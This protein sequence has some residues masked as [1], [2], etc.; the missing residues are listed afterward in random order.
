MEPDFLAQKSMLEEHCEKRGYEVIFF[1]KYH[2]ELN[3]IEQC[4][5]YAKRIYRMFPASSKEEDLEK[6]LLAALGSVPLASMRRFSVRSSR[7][8]DAYFHGLDGA[9]PLLSLTHHCK[10]I[11][12]CKKNQSVGL[13]FGPFALI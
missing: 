7:F 12:L 10:M 4:W 13:I 3:F 11:H 2:P 1:P 5:G 6:N 9:E 8:T